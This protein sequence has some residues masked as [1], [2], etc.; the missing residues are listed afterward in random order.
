MYFHDA[1]LAARTAARL[2]QAEAARRCGLSQ[3]TIGQMERGLRLPSL[4]A[5]ARIVTALGLEPGVGIAELAGEQ[6]D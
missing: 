5:Y 2:S 6:H 4:P 1:V 3:V